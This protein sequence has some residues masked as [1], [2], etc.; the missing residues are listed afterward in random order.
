MKI[1]VVEGGCS[2]VEDV[3]LLLWSHLL[4]FPQKRGERAH[5]WRGMTGSQNRFCTVLGRSVQQQ[6]NFVYEFLA[7]K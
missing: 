4:L 6:C 1:Q 5:Y 3:Y 7:R 2:S